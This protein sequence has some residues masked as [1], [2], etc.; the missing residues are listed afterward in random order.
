MT[1]D[2]ASQ[3]RFLPLGLDLRGRLCVIVGGGDVGTRKAGTLVSAGAS[4]TVVAPAVTAELADL[5][6]GDHVRWIEGSFVEEQIE[7]AFVVIAATDDAALNGEIVR[8]GSLRGALVCDAS[9]AQRSQV[10]FGALIRDKDTTVAVFTDGRDPAAA[11]R[12]RDQ[13]AQLLSATGTGSQ[14]G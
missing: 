14:D 11:R 3:L 7:G 6:D 13:I 8:A 4:V 1:S 9:A 5:V 12:K 2:S 10:I